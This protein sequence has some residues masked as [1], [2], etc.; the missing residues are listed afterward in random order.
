MPQQ[1]NAS[2]L[3]L[4]KRTL[5]TP[6][7]LYGYAWDDNGASTTPNNLYQ[8]ISLIRKAL[9]NTLGGQDDYIVTVPRKGFYINP[10]LSVSEDVAGNI[11]ADATLTDTKF[12]IKKWLASK[13]GALAIF[14]IMMIF[15]MDVIVYRTYNENIKLF[16]TYTELVRFQD[17]KF[18]SD[19]ELSSDARLNK[20]ATRMKWT[21]IRGKF[22]YIS[23]Y[24][25]T[26]P[27]SIISCQENPH[28]A[29]S[30][31]CSSIMIL[32]EAAQ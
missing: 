9:S 21:C 10:E 11:L 1:L 8:N 6:Q 12:P 19:P 4:M 32:D 31:Q 30:S 20:I 5:T 17:C 14:A 29:I 27:F 28:E 2:H 15:A 16:S 13:C 7:E 25:F 26:S 24:D 3:L 18:Y 22:N 23:G